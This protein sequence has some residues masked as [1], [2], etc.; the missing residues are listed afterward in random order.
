[1]NESMLATGG[2]L[3]FIKRLLILTTVNEAL[4]LGRVGECDQL[5]RSQVEPTSDR[6]FSYS[7][8]SGLRREISLTGARSSD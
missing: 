3:L 5:S 1:M 8:Q 4:L 6:S 7:Y 2:L